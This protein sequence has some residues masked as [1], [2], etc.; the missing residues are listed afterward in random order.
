MFRR[1]LCGAVTSL[2]TAQDPASMATAMAGQVAGIMATK[3]EKMVETWQK[4]VRCPSVRCSEEL[5]ELRE[6]AAMLAAIKGLRFWSGDDHR[7]LGIAIGD[8][9]PA[10]NRL[11]HPPETVPCIGDSCC[12]G[13]TCMNLPGVCQC[14]RGPCNEEGICVSTMLGS[15]GGLPPEQQKDFLP[16][17]PPPS[18]NQVIGQ[19][20][21]G[22][23]SG[24]GIPVVPIA[25]AL[26]AANVV[27]WGAIWCI[28]QRRSRGYDS[29][30]SDDEGTPMGYKGGNDRRFQGPGH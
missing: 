14:L 15:S 10:E 22:Q 27:I 21:N 12:I 3:A 30:S 18:Q 28:R 8:S 24:G 9:H 19:I 29:M 1:L 6:L 11:E 16:K 13:S 25:I 2:A 4:R 5:Q 7:Q 20:G 23:E 26:V 17:S